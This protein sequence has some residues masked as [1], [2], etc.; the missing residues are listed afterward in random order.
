MRSSRDVCANVVRTVA[1]LHTRRSCEERERSKNLL[2]TFCAHFATY[3]NVFRLFREQLTPCDIRA[4][5][6]RTS[7]D[8]PVTSVPTNIWVV[9][10]C[11]ENYCH[12]QFSSRYQPPKHAF[13]HAAL[14]L[15]PAQY[16]AVTPRA[17]LTAFPVMLLALAS[18]PQGLG[19]TFSFFFFLEGSTSA[20]SFGRHVQMESDTQFMR[21]I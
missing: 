14:G 20:L 15:G 5:F 6:V 18:P 8:Y 12:H 19:L 2:R 13:R 17:F 7:R 1:E 4:K 10:K 16:P 3:L 21:S 9:Y 11:L